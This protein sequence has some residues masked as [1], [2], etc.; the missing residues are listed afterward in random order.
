MSDADTLLA[1]MHAMAMPPF[2]GLLAALVAGAA[3][4]R[5]RAGHVRGKIILTNISKEHH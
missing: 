1:T 3:E 2:G 4:A 5:V